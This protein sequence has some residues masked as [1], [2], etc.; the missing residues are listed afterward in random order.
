MSDCRE[1]FAVCKGGP[2]EAVPPLSTDIGG[3]EKPV[4]SG[5][6]I[7]STEGWVSRRR[8]LR[9]RRCLNG[10]VTLTRVRRRR[11]NTKT[12]AGFVRSYKS[13]TFT[14]E[15]RPKVEEVRLI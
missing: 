13:S 4:F 8:L 7:L 2:D 3:G 9:D 12:D 14:G 1:N 11:R 5:V 15:A 6:A 10:S